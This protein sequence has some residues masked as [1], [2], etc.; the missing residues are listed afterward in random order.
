MTVVAATQNSNKVP[1]LNST[2]SKMAAIDLGVERIAL[3]AR[4]DQFVERRVGIL[5]AGSLPGAAFG[6]RTPALETI[7]LLVAILDVPAFLWERPRGSQ[8]MSYCPAFLHFL[9]FH[10]YPRLSISCDGRACCLIP[11]GKTMLTR[12]DCYVMFIF[13]CFVR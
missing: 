5:F 3:L 10:R 7:H 9:I 1:T 8:W 6:R 2:E 11:P 4:L 13:N 12:Q